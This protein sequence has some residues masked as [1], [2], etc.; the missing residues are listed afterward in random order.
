[1]NEGTGPHYN[2]QKFYKTAT[3]SD[4]IEVRTLFHID[5]LLINEQVAGI[6]TGDTK[7]KIFNLI[8]RPARFSNI[9]RKLG[10]FIFSY[11]NL[12]ITLYK[13]IVTGISVDPQSHQ[14]DVFLA[15]DKDILEILKS[16][17]NFELY[18][19][20]K[21]IQ[22][23]SER[24]SIFIENSHAFSSISDDCIYRFGIKDALIHGYV[25]R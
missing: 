11:G 19:K 8:G 9:F 21:K 23:Y 10:I 12:Q 13:D 3:S 6:T 14:N 25:T 5:E 7:E 1:M 24:E 16:R 17:Y 2:P 4:L 18:L 15:I 20:S 22:F